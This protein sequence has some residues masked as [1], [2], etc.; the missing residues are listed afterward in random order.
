MGP[1]HRGRQELRGL[2]ED[3]AARLGASFVRADVSLEADVQA[4]IEDAVDR[5]GRLDVLVNNAGDYG[6][7]GSIT[8]VDLK[9]FERTMAV[10]VGGVVAGMKHAAP[11]MLR[12]R[13]GSIIIVANIGGH[14]A[15]LRHVLSLN[16]A[17]RLALAR[18]HDES[19]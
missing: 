10:Q 4:L 7:A 9:R 19:A 5:H 6:T 18:L 12:Q 17:R 13:S 15:D 14:G 8:D 11:V 2:L 3:Y 16:P 1:N